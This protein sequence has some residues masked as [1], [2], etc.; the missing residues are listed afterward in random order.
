MSHSSKRPTVLGICAACLA[1]ILV[2]GACAPAPVAPSAPQAAATVA[3]AQS[4]LSLIGTEW[5]LES[6]FGGGSAI[7]VIEGSAPS[8]AFAV[9]RYLGYGGCDWFQGL[10]TLNGESLRFEPPAKS[11]GGCTS[12]QAQQKQQGTYQQ[13]LLNVQ[14]F[15]IEDGKLVLYGAGNERLLSMTSLQPV[16]FE[17][18]IWELVLRSSPDSAA[19]IP[20]I[21]N[22]T[23]TA[24]FDGKQVAG[25]AGCNDY[26]ATYEKNGEQLKVGPITT[27]RK[28]CG[29][30]EG[31]M[32]QETDYLSMLQKAARVEQLPR[33][34]LLSTDSSQPLLMYHAAP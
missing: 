16:P 3:G 10:H 27:T 5:Q 21:P 17:R 14:S 34:M 31:V 25:N 33:S 11:Q 4:E 8:L 19:A 18:T 30:P 12:D 2:V 1:M 28:A 7:P 20:M 23:I 24:K 26:N 32:E 6:M 22:T 13:L 9:N 15:K 29:E